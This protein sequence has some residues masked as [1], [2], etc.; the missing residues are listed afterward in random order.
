MNK[1]Q[2][3][4]LEAE[5]VAQDAHDGA[6]YRYLRDAA[7][8]SLLNKLFRHVELRYGS[9]WDCEIY[10]AMSAGMR[11]EVIALKQARAQLAAPAGVSART[12]DA[13]QSADWSGVS[14]GNKALISKAIELLAAP[15]P[16]PAS[17][18]DY[19]PAEIV[20][21]I[22]RSE[23]V[24]AVSMAADALR[25]APPSDVVQV[26][27][28]LL[29]RFAALF[30]DDMSDDKSGRAGWLPHVIEAVSDMRALLNGGRV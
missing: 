16:A 22:M 19:M 5:R 26:P 14:L 18:D 12:A 9:K 15:S 29:G 7:H 8:V 27:R 2:N 23:S 30:P 21:G 24:D 13:L 10:G 4:A 25:P 20:G 11:E 1:E 6:L 17:E 28:E 3:A